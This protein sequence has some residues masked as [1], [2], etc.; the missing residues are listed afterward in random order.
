MSRGVPVA[1]WLVL[2]SSRSGGSSNST[3]QPGRRAAQASTAG[4]SSATTARVTTVGITSHPT[5]D[6]HQVQ[7]VAVMHVLG[8]KA[9]VTIQH[10]VVVVG[11]RRGAGRVAER[12][13]GDTGGRADQL[14]VPELEGARVVRGAGRDHLHRDPPVVRARRA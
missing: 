6:V 7:G 1:G 13:G 8:R 12:V 4:S 3:V 9:L 2:T 5:A 11:E 14:V 10:H